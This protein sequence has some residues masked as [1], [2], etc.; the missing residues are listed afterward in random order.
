MYER[1]I[2]DFKDVTR[3][4]QEYYTRPDETYAMAREAQNT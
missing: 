1:N 4:I 3:V 2:T